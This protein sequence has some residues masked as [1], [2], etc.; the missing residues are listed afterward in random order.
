[1]RRRCCGPPRLGMPARDDPTVSSTGDRQASGP[2]DMLACLEGAASESVAAAT[3]A[4]RPPMAGSRNAPTSP[5]RAEPFVASTPRRILALLLPRLRV[6]RLRRPGP[7]AVWAQHG[8]HRQLISVSAEANAAGLRE[9]QALADAQAILPGVALA[10]A[11]PAGDAAALEQLA[12]WAL[13]FTPLVGLEGE[14]GLVLD[15]TGVG[16][17][18]WT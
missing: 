1:M 10:P 14:N 11:D 16:I 2:A 8:S 6:E 18:A 7:L 3:P 12:L 13:R 15:I 9:G 17:S 5:Q 4:P